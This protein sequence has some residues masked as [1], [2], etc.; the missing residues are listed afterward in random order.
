MAD[1]GTLVRNQYSET[2][3]P[4][5]PFPIDSVEAQQLVST[6]ETLTYNG[7]AAA[8]AITVNATETKAIVSIEG[9]QVAS[10]WGLEKNKVY[11]A[12]FEGKKNDSWWLQSVTETAG[13]ADFVVYDPNKDLESL[14]ESLTTTVKRFVAKLTDTSGNVLYGW[15][16]GVA[17]ATDVYTFTVANDRVTETQDWVGTLAS[18]TH[19][20]LEKVEIFKYRSSLTFGTGTTLTEEVICPVEYSKNW[21]KPLEYAESLTNGQY[22]VDYMRGRIIGK[23]ADAT[24]SETIT[25]NIWSAIASGGTVVASDVNVAK[26]G[27]VAVAVDD[28][29]MAATPPILPVG[30]E[31]R[32]APTTY[33]DGDAAVL[34]TDVNG[35]LK[36]AISSD[37]EIG[38]VELKD[39]TTDARQAV[40]VD[41]ATATATPTVALVGAIYKDAVDTYDDNDASPLHVDVNGNLKVSTEG[42]GNAPQAYG[43]DAAGDNAYTTVV[44]TT[45]DRHHMSVSVE[46][47]PAIISIDSGTTNHYYIPAGTTWVFD[48][49]LI[50]SGATIQGKN[51]TGGSN[52]V[53]LSISVW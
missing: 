32:A 51:G 10:Y 9:D 5:Q 41:N 35:Q 38:A 50:A 18:F 3:D 44:T 31:Y 7:K 49:I 4:T 17:E 13:S 20:S 16:F 27:G 29:A 2:V 25:Y 37:I 33:A 1:N 34:Q 22:F 23:K 30:G 46:T 28:S 39:G 40:K 26:V 24:A 21:Q 43:Q 12:Y 36:V 47:H 45:A 14:F 8:A 52:Y 48:N 15:V 19:T 11:T 42:E 53:N 6:S